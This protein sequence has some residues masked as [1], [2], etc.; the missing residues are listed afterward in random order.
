VKERINWAARL[1]QLFFALEPLLPAF[2]S[3]LSASC[4]LLPALCFLPSAPVF[5]LIFLHIETVEQQLIKLPQLYCNAA[6]TAYSE[7]RHHR[8]TGDQV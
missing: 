1:G 8:R 7:L 2:C 6:G 3:L 4:A 5:S